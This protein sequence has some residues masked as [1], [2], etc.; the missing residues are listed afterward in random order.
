MEE[1]STKICHQFNISIRRRNFW[2]VIYKEFAT[3]IEMIFTEINLSRAKK[4]NDLFYIWS[5]LI[6]VRLNNR[7][8]LQLGQ[9]TIIMLIRGSSYYIYYHNINNNHLTALSD[10]FSLRFSNFAILE[11]NCIARL[12][13]RDVFFNPSLYATALSRTFSPSPLSM[14]KFILI[15]SG[16][17]FK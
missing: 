6:L 4:Y 15:F 2:V 16:K 10:A 8:F 7:F 17:S 3:N 14:L 12:R 9:W 13:C 11:P 5:K 1:N